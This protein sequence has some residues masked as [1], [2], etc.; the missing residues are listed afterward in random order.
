M[1]CNI[2]YFDQTYPHWM[3]NI[4]LIQGHIFTVHW[5]RWHQDWLQGHLREVLNVNRDGEEQQQT[6]INFD[7][8]WI[9][10]WKQMNKIKSFLISSRLEL[11][12]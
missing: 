3:N 5:N 7:S 10:N 11:L 8:V 1:Q 9:E 6:K 4:R 12:G 2:F